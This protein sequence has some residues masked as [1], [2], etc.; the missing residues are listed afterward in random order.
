VQEISRTLQA[1]KLL[2]QEGGGRPGQT[3][4][5]H[6]Y[7]GLSKLYKVSCD[8]LDFLVEEA[9]KEPAIVGARM[10]GGGFG[11]CTINI[12]RR[13]AADEFLARSME[14]YKKKFNIRA[15][16]YEVRIWE[17]THEMNAT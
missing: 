3:H 4:V 16:A 14:R 8:E 9:A 2:E 17:G 12:I 11:G 1:A 7:E 10:V 5:Q 13:D 15:E 6:T